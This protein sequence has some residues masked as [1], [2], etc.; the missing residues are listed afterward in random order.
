MAHAPT[1]AAPSAGSELA[2]GAM[3]VRGQRAARKVQVD[4]SV[5]QAAPMNTQQAN[6]MLPEAHGFHPTE[7]AMG[8]GLVQ[9]SGG[10]VYRPRGAG[11][12]HVPTGGTV[13][14]V[15]ASPATRSPFSS[16][17]H[18]AQQEA[19]AAGSR[20]AGLGQA[21]TQLEAQQGVMNKAINRAGLVGAAAGTG[22]MGYMAAPREMGG[23]GRQQPKVGADERTEGIANRL[24]DLGIGILA[25]PYA[26]KG[27]ASMR[28]RGGVLGVV[29]RGADLAHNAMHQYETPMEL[30]GLALVA[31]GI[32]HGLASGI[33]KLRK[34]VPPQEAS[35]A[36]PPTPAA[37]SAGEKVGRMLARE[38]VAINVSALPAAAANF[39][40]KNKKPI[41]GL[42]AIGTVGAGLYGGKKTIDATKDLVTHPH[43]AARY[44]GVQPGMRPPSS[45]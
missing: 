41:A 15:G 31:P 35:S 26:A 7:S 30:A 27:L 11:V 6:A 5:A 13:A 9:G 17:L 21:A 32:T 23:V 3:P 25:A 34:P 44:T 22:L 4:A 1:M 19:S 2:T 8:P 18:T 45:V 40:W 10:Q 28:N 43:E 16:D 37:L 29:G 33:A 14:P 24:D 36:A 42:A 12:T 38:K 20:A 39:A